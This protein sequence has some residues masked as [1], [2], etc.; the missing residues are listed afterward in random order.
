MSQVYSSA[1]SLKDFF[2]EAE[3]K[4]QKDVL[5]LKP[6]VPDASL[7]KTRVACHQRGASMVFYMPPSA[8]GEGR[9]GRLIP[10]RDVLLH[11]AFHRQKGPECELNVMNN[12]VS[13]FDSVRVLA[14]SDPKGWGLWALDVRHGDS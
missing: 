12:V 9:G 11:P 14:M 1:P 5:Y 8:E 7:P 2:L 6:S 10:P 13:S 4:F 3:Y